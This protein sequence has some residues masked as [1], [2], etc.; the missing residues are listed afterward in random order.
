MGADQ[1][2]VEAQFLRLAQGGGGRHHLGGAVRK[3]R[4]HFARANGFV[5]VLSAI[6]P[7]RREISSWIHCWF[8]RCK[9]AGDETRLRAGSPVKNSIG[10][11]GWRGLQTSVNISSDTVYSKG[12]VESQMAPEPPVKVFPAGKPRGLG[13]PGVRN[14][15]LDHPPPSPMTR[16]TARNSPPQR[17]YC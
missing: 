15:A 10:D 13:K 1:H 7:A 12:G 17:E 5:H 6:L 4:A 2:Q 14:A 3:D 11:S 9:T 8:K 16:P